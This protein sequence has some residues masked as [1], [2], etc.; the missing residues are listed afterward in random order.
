MKLAEATQRQQRI[1][2]LIVDGYVDEGFLVEH[3]KL[4]ETESA[5][6]VLE[7]RNKMIEEKIGS[8]PDFSA[9]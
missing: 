5:E 8:S 3:E 1:A 6:I 9:Q 2:R 4:T 7:A